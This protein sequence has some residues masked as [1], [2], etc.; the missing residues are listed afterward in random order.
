[1]SEI[2]N[3]AMPF[4]GLIVLG[5]FASRRWQVGEHG[6]AWLNI[7][8][9]Y[10]SLPA[11]IFLVVAAAPFEQLINW[12]F[13][14]ATTSVTVFAFLAIVILS[15]LFFATP[16]KTAAL[17]GTAGSYGNVGYMG[18]PLS[19]AFFGPEAAV[20][21][22]LVFCF[23]CAVQF[24]MTAFLATLAH[25]RN[26]E[27][28]WGEVSLRIVKQVV[29]HPFI[30]A[31][32]LGVL[33][34]ALEFKAPGAIGTMLDMLMRAA[35]PTALFALGVTVGMRK[36][37]GFG[38]ELGLVTA[39]KVVIQP[40]LAFFVVSLVP[41]VQPMWLHVAVMM[42]ALPTAS[43]AFILAS[44]NKTYVEGASTAVIVTTLASALT[45]PILIYAIK[46]GVLP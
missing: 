9:V 33:A 5:V 17:Q 43:N 16:L 15:R 2:L 26:E 18:L 3:L 13:V 21:A 41:G 42:A 6:L 44:Q 27:A 40:V 25:E 32:A 7:F 10:F 29:S 30:I 38:P 23:D 1:M 4:F 8:L 45:I 24:I 34:S 19:V 36:F 22:A 11:L 39:M 46:A 12:P 14:T 37:E 35:G 28:H 31:T 20:P